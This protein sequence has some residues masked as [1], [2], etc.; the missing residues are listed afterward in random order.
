[1]ELVEI[2]NPQK[3]QAVVITGSGSAANEAMLSSVV[4]DQKILILSNGEFGERLHET[5]SIYNRHTFILRF[6]WG[7]QLDFEVI[8]RYLE[9]HAIDVI[10]VVHHETSSG[11]LNSLAEVGELAQAH[12]ATLREQRRGGGH[13]HGTR[14]HCVLFCVEFKGHRLVSGFVVR[15]WQDGGVRE[16][17]GA[18]SKNFVPEFV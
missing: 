15:D 14:P 7:E 17:C 16:D 3:Y 6:P 10:A 5:S 18:T 9:T 2:R 11:M 4:G 13:R 1:L 8:D 12:G